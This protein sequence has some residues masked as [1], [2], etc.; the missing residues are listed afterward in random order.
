MEYCKYQI[1]LPQ[2][3][4]ELVKE[5]QQELQTKSKRK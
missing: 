2:L 3:Q 4:N 1:A 5:Y